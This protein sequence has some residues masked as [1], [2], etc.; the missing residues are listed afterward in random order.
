MEFDISISSLMIKNCLRVGD[1]YRIPFNKHGLIKIIAYIS[2]Y[3]YC[4]MLE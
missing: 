3:I 2:N 4:F 1:A